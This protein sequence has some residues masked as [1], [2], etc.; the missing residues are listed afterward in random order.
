M[1]PKYQDL[2][3]QRIQQQNLE[4][5]FVQA[6]EHTPEAFGR[7]VM[8]Y[9]SCSVNR[10]AITAFIDSGAQMT[11]MNERTAE[12]CG[13]LRLMDRRMAGV[14]VGVGTSK[15]LGRIH[16]TLVNLGGVHLPMSI[17]V[18]ESQDMEFLIGLDQLRRHQMCIDLKSNVLRLEEGVSLPFLAEGDLPPHLRG[19]PSEVVVPPNQEDPQNKPSSS[20]STPPPPHLLITGEAATTRRGGAAPPPP[21]PPVVV[22]AMV[23]RLMDL[24]GSSRTAVV[25][26]LE[27]SNWNEDVAAGF[28][29]E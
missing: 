28:L 5:N 19:G 16:M 7:V 15:I 13:I 27:A 17:T 14:A 21:P 4:D 11:I 3:F 22:D 23:Q 26:A 8:L 29:F 18:L 6:Y 24:S 2:L 25:G 12:R 9:I 10:T 1:D 20:T